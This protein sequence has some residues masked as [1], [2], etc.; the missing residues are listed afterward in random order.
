[1]MSRRLT[2]FVALGV[3]LGV[4][5][6]AAGTMAQATTRARVIL[7]VTPTFEANFTGPAP[8]VTTIA[9]LTDPAIPADLRCWLKGR[10]GVK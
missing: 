2:S 10:E 4:V 3:A 9:V 8:D 6:A 5:L 7:P 1:M